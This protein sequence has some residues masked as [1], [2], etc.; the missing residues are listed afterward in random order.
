[1]YPPQKNTRILSQNI[2]KIKETHNRTGIFI[3]ML[4]AHSGGVSAPATIHT[5]RKATVFG[6]IFLS[7]L[8]GQKNRAFRYKSSDLPMQILWAFRCNPLRAPSGGPPH[9][10]PCYHYPPRFFATQKTV[11]ANPRNFAAQNCG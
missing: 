9:G 5:S 10:G 8:S 4:W 1:M 6:R 11:A 3:I 2:Q 7:A